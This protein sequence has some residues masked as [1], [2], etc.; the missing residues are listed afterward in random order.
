MVLKRLCKL[1]ELLLLILTKI[2]RLEKLLHRPVGMFNLAWHLA[3]HM[4]ARHFDPG[5]CESCRWVCTGSM[6]DSN[7]LFNETLAYL[8]ARNLLVN[9]NR[10]STCNRMMFAPLPAASLTSSSALA[11]LATARQF[12]APSSFPCC[13]RLQPLLGVTSFTLLS[14]LPAANWAQATATLLLCVGIVGSNDWASSL[15][16][17][18]WMSGL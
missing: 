14:Q 17:R 10:G 3:K 4:H 6:P 18:G 13:Y 1:E 2:R 12:L 15:H 5:A 16:P 11:W 9:A 8:G 7:S